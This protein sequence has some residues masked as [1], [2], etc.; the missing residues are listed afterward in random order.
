SSPFALIGAGIGFLLGFLTWN[1]LF[2]LSVY[3]S[4]AIW[5]PHHLG[6]AGTLI[7]SLGA[8]ALL[9]VLV[10]RL[11][12]GEKRQVETAYTVRDVARR[13]FVDRWPPAL[14]G[15][16]VGTISAI[17]FLRV[18]PLGVTA[19]LGSIARTAGTSAGLLPESL[20]GLDLL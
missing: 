12:S 3:A 2:T 16:A 17:A 15:I 6:Y 8:L 20:H 1:P 4:P 13:V 5:L 19:E 11:S 9:A 18:A 7:F 10:L 14:A